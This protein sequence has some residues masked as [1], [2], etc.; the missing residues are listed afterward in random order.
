MVGFRVSG[1]GSDVFFFVCRPEASFSMLLRLV[2]G[3]RVSVLMYFL[4]SFRPEASFSI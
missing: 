2:Q 4:G 3:C 1:L